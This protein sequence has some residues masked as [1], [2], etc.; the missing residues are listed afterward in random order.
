ML[1]DSS[2]KK[3]PAKKGWG[4]PGAV[5]FG[6]LTYLLPAVILTFLWPSVQPLLVN[7]N[8]ANFVFAALF[9]AMIIIALFI[10][11]R[12]YGFKLRDLGL[13]KFKPSHI[14]LVLGG[15]FLYF[16]VTI[17]ISTIFSLFVDYDQDQV[18]ELGFS[19]PQG[20]EI[21]LVFLSL[22]VLAPLAEELLFR[23]FV[24]KGMRRRLPFWAAAILVSLLFAVVHGQVNVG[25]DVFALSLVLCWLRE[26][27]GSLWP[28]IIL[29]A[30]KNGIAFL[31]LFVLAAG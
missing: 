5:F 11:V 25:V 8:I 18:Q 26:T 4:I 14:W 30:F 19:N 13:N 6:A 1:D 31:L 22:V 23:G 27:T 29:H 2:D 7:D 20:L 28:A 24:Y 3:E 9:E 12:A 15:F 17:V 10:V 21:V 16:F